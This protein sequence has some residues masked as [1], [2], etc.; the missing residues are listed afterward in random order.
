MVQCTG[1]GKRQPSNGV[2][3]DFDFDRRAWNVQSAD[4]SKIT[5]FAFDPTLSDPQPRSCSTSDGIV[6]S[7]LITRD[8]GILCCRCNSFNDSPNA[9]SSPVIPN[10]CF[11]V[12]E[13]TICLYIRLPLVL[14]LLLVIIF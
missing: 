8:S 6:L 11:W 1:P 10:R 4:G 9:V 7:R 5:T 3:F 12:A 13:L 2:F 14:S